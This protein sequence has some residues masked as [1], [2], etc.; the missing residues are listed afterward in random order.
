MQ[1]F[2][3]VM[4]QSNPMLD[5]KTLT[6]GQAFADQFGLQ[7]GQRITLCVGQLC[8]ELTFIINNREVSAQVLEIHPKIFHATGMPENFVC[9]I[10]CEEN[11]IRLGP[12]IGVMADR[13][14]D[15]NRPYRDQSLFISQLINEANEIGAVCFAFSA[16]DIDFKNRIIKGCTF[17]K[18]GWLQKSY[19]FPDVIYVRYKGHSLKKN[20]IRNRLIKAG[21][22]FINPAL[23][24]KWQSYKILS[25][26]ESFRRYLPDTRLFDFQGLDKMMAKYSGVYLKPVA[27]S[28]GKDIIKVKKL[29]NSQ[30]TCQYRKNER[31]IRKTFGTASNLHLTI[32]KMIGRQAYIMQEQIN[33]IKI[34]GGPA[35]I[36]VLVQKNEKGSWMVTGKAGRIGSNGS[37]TSNISS[38]GKACKVNELLAGHFPDMQ[39]QQR[40]DQEIN[41]LS[42]EAAETIDKHFES[43]GELG[44]DIGLDQDGRLWFIEANLKPARKV[45][46]LIGAVQTRLLSVQRPLQYARW[47]AGF[48]KQ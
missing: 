4:M 18:K 15:P 43:L 31:I 37:I 30:Y 19:P 20:D 5:L 21:C 10:I 14:T 40:I 32:K 2:H 9:G 39:D 12:F 17:H 22:K 6:S 29:K 34:S 33:L 46:N 35:D 11:R 42:L 45:F 48:E 16:G 25:R 41:S 7:N 23:M 8:K 27:G 13:S 38:G 24:G 1:H 36:R 47:L 3:K 44:I 26:Q 28:Q